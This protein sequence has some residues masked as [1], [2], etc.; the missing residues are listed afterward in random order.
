DPR[1]LV[2]EIKGDLDWIAI[3]ALEKDRMRRYDTAS[4]LGRDI[5]RYLSSEPVEAC[6]P[7]RF[8]RLAKTIHRNKGIFAAGIALFVILMAGTITSL[9]AAGRA[10]NG[11]DD[12]SA[13]GPKL[14]TLART[15]L[16]D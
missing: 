4:A 6:P 3:K 12:L 2:R 5:E 11:L 14:S 16:D 8:Y 7:S 9:S 10:Y 13:N 1:R 15:L